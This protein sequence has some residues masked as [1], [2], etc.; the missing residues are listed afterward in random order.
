M[1]GVKDKPPSE[2]EV[3]DVRQKTLAKLGEEGLGNFLANDIEKLKSSDV[4][5][6]MFWKHVFNLPGDQGDEAAAMVVKTFKWRKEFGE[7]NKQGCSE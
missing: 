5:V 2:P 6:S 7:K 3:Q 1:P 4:Y